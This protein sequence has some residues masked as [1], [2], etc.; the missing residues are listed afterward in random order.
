MSLRSVFSACCLS[1]ALS[2][3]VHAQSAPEPIRD[4]SFLIEEAY[5]QDRGVVQ[6]INTFSVPVSGA[7]WNYSFS[8]E[9]PVAGMRHQLSYTIPVSAA[10]N[11]AGEI[12]DIALHY[13][14]QLVG[15]NGGRLYVSPRASLVLSTGDSRRGFGAGAT[16]LQTMLPVSFEL[17][18]RFTLHGNAGLT[19]TRHARNAAED[20]ATTTSY[21]AG[22]SAI[23]LATSTF[24]ALVETSWNRIG[25]VVAPGQVASDKQWVVSPGIRWA[26]NLGEMQVVPG[27]A[28]TIGV[29]PS[30]GTNALFLYLSIEH[31]FA[32]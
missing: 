7:G 4:N 26:H 16:G 25:S 2:A 23:W 12:G 18:P 6:H 9:W 24:N 3:A 21:T 15:V 29:G 11:S 27:I 17:S 1:L 28:Y 20:R 5:N 10:A 31:P 30:R 8:Q 32:H 14:L 19:Y 22:A 13:R